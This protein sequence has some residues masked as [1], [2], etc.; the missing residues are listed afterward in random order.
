[1]ATAPEPDHLSALDCNSCC[2]S[3]LRKVN[4]EVRCRT[5]FAHVLHLIRFFLANSSSLES[6]TFKVGLG[7]KQSDTPMLLS[8]SQ[9]LLQ[10]YATSITESTSSVH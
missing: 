10:I 7:L 5:T 2:L 1:M 4:I 8:I 6:L 3:H 9:D